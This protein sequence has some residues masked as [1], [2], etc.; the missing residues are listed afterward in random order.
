[1][2]VSDGTELIV[3]ST[4]SESKLS[5]TSLELKDDSGLFTKVRG[6]L[7]V[8]EVVAKA[9]KLRN[10]GG[11]HS[12]LE[13]QTGNAVAAVRGTIFA[14]KVA[15]EGGA[16]SSFTLIAGS[17]QMAETSPTAT[18]TVTGSGVVNDV[19]TVTE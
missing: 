15:Q 12:E 2:K 3:G 10:I 7:A 18:M 4:E 17:L 16:V 13:I 5:L 1:M 14:A 19:I 9:P 8:G 11:T 6:M